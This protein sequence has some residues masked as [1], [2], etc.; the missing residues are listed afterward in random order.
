MNKNINYILNMKS[1]IKSLFVILISVI[2]P[3]KAQKTDF[4]L[5]FRTYPSNHYNSSIVVPVNKDTF[6]WVLESTLAN[7]QKRIDSFVFG[8]NQFIKSTQFVNYTQED[9]LINKM[10]KGKLDWQLILSPIHSEVTQAK[11]EIVSTINTGN[12][13]YLYCFVNADSIYL[14][15]SGS[16][17][18]KYN[19]PDTSAFILFKVDPE[20]NIEICN[21]FL[22]KNSSVKN[23]DLV[24]ANNNNYAIFFQHNP[25]LH[26]S[27][28]KNLPFYQL[29]SDSILKGYLLYF[30]NNNKT[31]IRWMAGTFPLLTDFGNSQK[32]IGNNLLINGDYTSYSLIGSYPHQ[33]LIY[34]SS[35]ETLKISKPLNYNGQKN[36]LYSILIDV[37]EWRVK[38]S[39]V[40]YPKKGEFGNWDYTGLFNNG[41]W[42]KTRGYD[43]IGFGSDQLNWVGASVNVDSEK[44]AIWVY[45]FDK[46][47]LSNFN[48]PDG[49]KGVKSNGDS[50]LFMYGDNTTSFPNNP[51]VDFDNSSIHHYPL[52]KGK[53]TACY[54]FNGELIWARNEDLFTNSLERD[55][56]FSKN[57][58]SYTSKCIE[59][60]TDL[61]YGFRKLNKSNFGNVSGSILRLSKAPISDFDI[62]S[63]N[64]NHININYKGSL[65]ANFYFKFSDGSNDSIVNSRNFLYSFKKTGKFI[66][67]AVAYNNFGRDTSFYSVEISEINKTQKL[68]MN[69][70]I[71]FYPNPTSNRIYW[72]LN[73]TQ[74]VEIYDLNGGL[75]YSNYQIVNELNIDWLNSGSYL[76]VVINP[77]GSFYN[78]ILKSN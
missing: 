61:D 68:K 60:R 62:E 71:I 50:L 69:N 53:F 51:E 52:K 48:F 72:D 73:N 4:Y 19:I 66:V 45:D 32:F 63:I 8:N 37:G 21:M 77:Q 56:Y 74:Q 24:W 1:I 58:T 41:I 33:P 17:I 43:T 30:E 59:N 36:Y 67:Y 20:S 7:K 22:A 9:V 27:I 3:L 6:F 10:V 40:W 34:T 25:N 46:K 31:A 76:I 38:N 35:P 44:S 12:N 13:F 49:V 64:N 26:F 55:I 54:R 65:N 16:K 11:L 5:Q 23:S 18:E 78:I 28:Y 14:S 15:R 2:N 42:F 39:E 70:S 47:R 75:L 29:I 57:G